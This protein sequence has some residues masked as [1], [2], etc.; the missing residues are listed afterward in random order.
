[1]KTIRSAIL[2]AIGGICFSGIFLIVALAL[3]FF[4][5][6]TIYPAVHILARLQLFVM[7]LRLKIDGYQNFDPRH[8]YLIMGNHES[9]FDLLAIPA[10]IPMHVVAIEAAYHFS[11]PLWGYLIK[12]WGVIPIHRRD[13]TKAM[14]SLDQAAA[15][16]QSGISIVVLPEGHRTLTGKI[17]EFKK[18]PFHLAR[19]ARA[20]ILPFALSGLFEYCSKQGWHLMPRTARVLFGEPIPYDTFK[21]DPVEEIQRKVRDRIIGLKQ[22]ADNL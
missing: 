4:S 9:L 19:A 11:L 22:T 3:L 18:G 10:A 12:K 20:D 14:A 16:L 8:S 1:V 17:G 15:V 2:W 13:L 6:R 7:G 5:P 21:N